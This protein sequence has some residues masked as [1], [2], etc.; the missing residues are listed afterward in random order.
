MRSQRSLSRFPLV[1]AGALVS[2]AIGFMAY[3]STLNP[4]PV[5]TQMEREISLEGLSAQSSKPQ[6]MPAADDDASSVPLPLP[7]Q[8][9]E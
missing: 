6:A 3:L 7:T 9:N 1:L 4:M 2:V 8:D 5:V